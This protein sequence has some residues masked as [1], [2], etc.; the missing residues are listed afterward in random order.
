MEHFRIVNEN[1][2][3]IVNLVMDQIIVMNV[4]MDLKVLKIKHN[5]YVLQFQIVNF[6]KIKHIVQNVKMIMQLL[7]IMLKNVLVFFN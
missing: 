3:K 6:A 7:I 1:K 5:V 4:Q 2:R